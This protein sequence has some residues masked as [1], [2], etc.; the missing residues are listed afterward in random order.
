MQLPPSERGCTMETRRKIQPGA[1]LAKKQS[2]LQRMQPVRDD[3]FINT[4][5]L[6]FIRFFDPL[7]NCNPSYL[8][9]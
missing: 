6:E 8:E 4:F 3:K 2:L 7:Y 9:N 1:K 5:L